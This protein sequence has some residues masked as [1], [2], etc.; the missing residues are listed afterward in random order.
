M[1]LNSLDGLEHGDQ[2]VYIGPDSLE[3]PYVPPLD[4]DEPYT[5][6][7]VS[8]GGTLTCE[9]RFGGR[10]ILEPEHPANDPDHWRLADS[11]EGDA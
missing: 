1:M 9:T 10:K 5:F 6:K 11:E 3:S 4:R 2:I 7:H 8:V